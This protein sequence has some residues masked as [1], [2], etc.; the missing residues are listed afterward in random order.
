MDLK[1]ALLQVKHQNVLKPSREFAK[2]YVDNF[3]SVL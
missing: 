1:I 2:K 3:P